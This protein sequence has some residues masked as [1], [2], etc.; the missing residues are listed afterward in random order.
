[1]GFQFS[2]AS[3]LLYLYGLLEAKW[4]GR[5]SIFGQLVQANSKSRDTVDRLDVL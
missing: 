3:E 2:K 5:R 4:P 1:M